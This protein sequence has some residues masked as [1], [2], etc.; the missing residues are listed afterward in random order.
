MAVNI[1]W[2]LRLMTIFALC[3]F[4]LTSFVV[5]TLTGSSKIHPVFDQQNFPSSPT[6]D[7]AEEKYEIKSCLSTD[8]EIHEQATCRFYAL[9]IDAGSTGTRIHI[10]EF[11]HDLQN[12][13]MQILFFFK[14]QFTLFNLDAQKLNCLKVLRRNCS[15]VHAL[16]TV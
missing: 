9:M 6:A 14:R 12:K 2:P 10:F 13:G 5:F 1:I 3:V 16:A 8:L 7:D 4:I 11:S 15:V